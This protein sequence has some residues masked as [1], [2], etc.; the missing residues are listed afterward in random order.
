MPSVPSVAPSQFRSAGTDVPT[1]VEWMQAA[2]AMLN[3]VG[4]FAT[5][6]VGL[7]D[8]IGSM[9]SVLSFRR[10]QSESAALQTYRDRMLAVGELAQGLPIG[11]D[12][13]EKQIDTYLDDLLVDDQSLRSGL[14]HYVKTPSYQAAVNDAM[15]RQRKSQSWLQ[16]M[17]FE[18]LND[19]HEAQ[20]RADVARAQSE[21]YESE[22]YRE[23]SAWQYRRYEEYDDGTVAMMDFEPDYDSAQRLGLSNRADRE[24]DVQRHQRARDVY[25]QHLTNLKETISRIDKEISVLEQYPD[26]TDVN[27]LIIAKKIERM[28]IMALGNESLSS[29]YDYA[30]QSLKR[31]YDSI[32]AGGDDLNVAFG[33]QTL[34]E[35]KL[36]FSDRI[37]MSNV[38]SD[39]GS[40]DKVLKV[41]DMLFNIGTSLTPA[42]RVINTT[43]NIT[44]NVTKNVIKP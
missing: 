17:T 18:S 24:Q 6:V 7:V 27:S 10:S 35:H 4:T 15:M 9:S 13:T 23:V 38:M 22:F 2:G 30:I 34:R 14:K 29:L 28:Q 8:Q 12:I 3:Q 31:T 16:T 40:I 11:Q 43:K 19:F 39:D 5:Q 32:A 25:R 44:Q 37:F 36:A 20:K 1:D 42:G 21:Q 41:V 33:E 26:S